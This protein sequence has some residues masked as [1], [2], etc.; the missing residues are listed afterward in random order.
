MLGYLV[1]GIVVGEGNEDHGGQWNN[2]E[3]KQAYHREGEECDVKFAVTQQRNVL[4]E[5]VRASANNGGLLQVIG[6][7]YRPQISQDE[8]QNDKDRKNAVKDDVK[9]VVPRN[10]DI[11]PQLGIPY[12]GYVGFHSPY[13]TA[14]KEVLKEHGQV[15][16][17]KGH[18]IQN[19]KNLQKEVDSSAYGLPAANM[20]QAH[21]KVGA[22]GDPVAVGKMRKEKKRYPPSWI[23]SEMTLRFPTCIQ[24]L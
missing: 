13:V 9:G 3:E 8:K 7:S 12:V 10:L 1:V 4:F 6:F 16:T 24:N 21:Q 14:R 17:A 2:G 5:S 20:S 19:E 23:V 22:L 18:G 11:F 15:A